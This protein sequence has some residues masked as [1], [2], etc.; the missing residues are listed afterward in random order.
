MS[1]FV[2]SAWELLPWSFLFDY[3]SNIGDILEMSFT[4]LDNVKWINRTILQDANDWYEY[5]LNKSQLIANHNDGTY[6]R[7]KGYSEEKKCFSQR[8]RRFFSRT[9]EA[10][11]VSPLEFEL[12]G[13]PQKWL[14]M[15]ALLL[16]AHSLHPQRFYYKA[17]PRLSRAAR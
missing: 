6:K 15:T 14:N 1:Q 11:S 7:F 9:A 10:P 8:T 4:S 2:P 13:K 16:Q 3:F 5:Q 17:N 12:P